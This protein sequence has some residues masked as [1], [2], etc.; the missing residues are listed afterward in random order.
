M[1]CMTMHDLKH[2]REH[3]NGVWRSAI[4][5][6]A[7]IREMAKKSST[8]KNFSSGLKNPRLDHHG[9][10]HEE[11]SSGHPKMRTGE[12]DRAPTNRK[13]ATQN[14]FHHL[15]SFSSFFFLDT[16]IR[17]TTKG[18]ELTDGGKLHAW[19]SIWRR[20]KWQLSWRCSIWRKKR[21]RW[22]SDDQC[23]GQRHGCWWLFWRCWT[24]RSWQCLAELRSSWHPGNGWR[25][26]RL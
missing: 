11:S 4:G 8:S 2:P 15:K 23:N 12:W 16:R 5:L 9:E 6:I 26:H 7:K 1:M 13:P 14:H 25:C 3:L 18:D 10:K 17:A 22:R 19:C 24:R 20:K 21:L